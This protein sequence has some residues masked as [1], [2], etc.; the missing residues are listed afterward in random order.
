MLHGWTTITIE[1]ALVIFALIIVLLRIYV[2]LTTPRGS[3]NHNLS[4]AIVICAW[5]ALVCMVSCDSALL[6]LGMMEWDS[7][8]DAKMLSI[9]SN[10]EDSRRMLKVGTTDELHELSLTKSCRLFSSPWFLTPP[11]FILSKQQ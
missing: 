4:D 8:Y 1:W 7:T 3:Q 6:K 10:P 2:R 11:S 9:N 5:L